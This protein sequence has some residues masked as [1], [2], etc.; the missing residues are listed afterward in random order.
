MKIK[1][2]ASLSVVISSVL[3]GACTTNPVT[4]RSEM[5]FVSTEK[6]ISIGEENYHPMQQTQGGTYVADPELVAYVQSVG[7]KLAA[8]SDRKLPYEFV[9][10]NDSVPNAWALP[11]GKIAINRGL[12]LEL[13]SE[14]ELAAVLGHEV[15]HAAARHSAKKME[16]GMALNIGLIVLG[17]SQR[18]SDYGRAMVA[19]GAVGMALLTQKYSRDAESEA[20]KY[21]IKYMVKAG[22][23]PSAAVKL[24]ETFVRLSEGKKPGWVEGMFASH[25]PSAER[26]AANKV[27]AKQYAK[28][29]L[30][31]GTKIYNRKIA[32]LKRSK[33]AYEDYNKAGAALKKKN[34]KEATKLINKAIKKEDRESLFYA[35]KGDIFEVQKKY[36]KAIPLYDQAIYLN[37]DLF[38]FYL[39]R[40]TSYKALNKKA[41]A[42]KDL[43]KSMALLPTKQA[44]QAL[45]ELK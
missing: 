21:G 9:I 25:P 22:Y 2:I 35:F 44:Q 7:N 10:I 26:V 33:Q 5:G 19:G 40:G 32:R 1:L 13:N 6:E 28:A 37:P 4:G 39:R 36:S 3:L 8:Q 24:Q 43:T 12:L 29:G 31:T 18:D 45:K 14:A 23:D 38:Y 27:L 17:V 16:T 42:K 15:V 30:K 34:Y 20:D 11:G 41:K